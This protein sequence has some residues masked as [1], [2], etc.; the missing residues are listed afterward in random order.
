MLHGTESTFEATEAALEMD[1]RSRRFLPH[2]PHYSDAK[3]S[4]TMWG[5]PAETFFDGKAL[6]A[7][8]PQEW[9]SASVPSSVIPKGASGVG[10]SPLELDL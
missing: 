6:E 4:Q 5:F 1:R 2:P 10:R 9:R 7:E 8:Y 3:L